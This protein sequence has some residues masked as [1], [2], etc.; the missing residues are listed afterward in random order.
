MEPLAE[1]MYICL[2]LL[3]LVKY[4]YYSWQFVACGKLTRVIAFI[5]ELKKNQTSEQMSR[6]RQADLGSTF[7]T[8]AVP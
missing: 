5:G 6:L 4:R 7:T 3:R 2:G 8:D 1:I